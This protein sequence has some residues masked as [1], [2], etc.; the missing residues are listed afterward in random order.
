[1]VPVKPLKVPVLVSA[2]GADCM[3]SPPNGT[4][5]TF[6]VCETVFC[7]NEEMGRTRKTSPTVKSAEHSF[8][9]Q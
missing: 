4:T 1:M 9:R 3:K 8:S 6:N 7:A 2:S 5:V